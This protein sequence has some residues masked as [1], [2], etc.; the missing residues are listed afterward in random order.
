MFGSFLDRF[1]DRRLEIRSVIADR[2][3]V[4]I[5]YDYVAASPGGMPGLPPRGEQVRT[6]LCSV[7]LI[8]DRRIQHW[9]VI[10]VDRG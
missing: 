2:D 9:R 3:R 10:E 8:R 1:P 5:E 6:P 7:A 4:A